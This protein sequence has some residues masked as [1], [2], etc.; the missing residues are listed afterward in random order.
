MREGSLTNQLI[1]IFCRLKQCQN[2]MR[3]SISTNRKS[4][5]QMVIGLLMTLTG[6]PQ[7]FLLGSIM[8]GTKYTEQKTK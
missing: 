1:I 4:Y 3:L 5:G 6:T 8:T 2:C 7:T